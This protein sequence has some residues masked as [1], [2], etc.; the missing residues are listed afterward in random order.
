MH[1][2]G[3]LYEIDELHLSATPFDPKAQS[4][5]IS[6]TAKGRLD[7]STG[8]LFL[9][10]LE[11]P[12]TSGIGLATEGLKLSGLG[13]TNGPISVDASL[14]GDLAALDRTL[15]AW[16]QSPLRGLGGGWSGRMTLARQPGGNL[17]FNGRIASANLVVTSPRGPVTL[18]VKG[19]YATSTDQLDL[20]SLDLATTFGRLVVGGKV[21]EVTTK[22]LADISGSLEPRWETL[23]PI[24][25]LA[26][27]PQ[28]QVRATFNPFHLTGSIA[29]DSVSQILKGIKGEIPLDLTA[30]QAFGLKLGATTITLRLTGG[31]ANFDPISTTLNEGKVKINADLF[32][33][34]PDALW[35]RLS[36]GSSIVDAEINE[37]VSND[38]LSYIAPILSKS[39]HVSG[40]VSL[41]IDDAAIPLVG[42]GALRV[43]GR[44]VFDGVNFQPGPFANE[45]FSLTGKTPPQMTLHQPVQLQIADGRV[46]QSGLSIPLASNVKA[47]LEGSVGFDKTLS[48]RA[49]LPVTPQM[50]GND[51]TVRQIVGDTKITVPIGGTISHPVIDRAGFR[52]A[53]KDAT[54]SIVKRGVKAEAG[55]LLDQ[56]IPST[57]G[58]MPGGQTRDPLKIFEE[59]GRDL[60]QPKNR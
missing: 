20:A 37:A 16:T 57:G 38:I 11:G 34:D 41:T 2:L 29:G 25:A 51:A 22:R 5:A 36:K 54:R 59:A 17:G 9:T 33:D 10:P 12:L 30:A 56:V 35:L 15:S 48:I 26:V 55:R 21:V 7:L 50:L 46:K 3:P 52:L 13:K 39:S 24:I 8:E 43:D 47:N 14:V 40:K 44:L 1:W 28:A 4:S 19:T 45:L 6:L 49:Q 42:E 60:I 18:A 58:T 27:E 31:K 32:L 53:L 23:D